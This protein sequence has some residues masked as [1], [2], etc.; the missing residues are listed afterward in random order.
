VGGYSAAWVC[1]VVHV[2]LMKKSCCCLYAEAVE[3]MSS[4][5]SV[6]HVG[7]SVTLSTFVAVEHGTHGLI[8][9]RK[10]ME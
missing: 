2:D 9:M 1:S 3:C 6:W 5:E 4:A 8:C 10:A 7:V